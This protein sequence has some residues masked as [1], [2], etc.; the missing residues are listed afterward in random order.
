MSASAHHALAQ[1]AGGDG[2]AFLADERAV[3]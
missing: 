2:L 3:V 1:L